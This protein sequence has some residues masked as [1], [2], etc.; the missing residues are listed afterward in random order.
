MQIQ[1]ADLKKIGTLTSGQINET[2]VDPA[3]YDREYVTQSEMKSKGWTSTTISKYLGV[4]D[5][6]ARNPVRRRAAQMRLYKVDRVEAA[7]NSPEFKAFQ[8]SR[9]A[10]KSQR[11]WRAA[12]K[13]KRFQEFAEKYKSWQPALLDA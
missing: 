4:P 6:L 1:S 9:S 2:V 7:E 5:K 3:R 11:E 8:Q 10:Q 12:A 13:E